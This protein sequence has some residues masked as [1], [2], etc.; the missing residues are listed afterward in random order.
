MWVAG[1][2]LATLRDADGNGSYEMRDIFADNLHAPCGLAFAD[3]CIY[4][5]NQ[6]ALVRRTTVFACM[7]RSRSG[8]SIDSHGRP[9][10]RWRLCR[11]AG[12]WNRTPPVGYIDCHRLFSPRMAKC[13]DD[14]WA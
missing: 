4:V 2:G 5:V 6:D 7:W 1:K 12:S 13:A 11:R 3:G 14:R 8:I 10:C 9:I